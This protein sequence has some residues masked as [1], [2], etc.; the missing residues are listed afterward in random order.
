MSD[1]LLPN[2]GLSTKYRA[3]KT[4]GIYPRAVTKYLWKFI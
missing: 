2:N 3:T 4:V 1:F